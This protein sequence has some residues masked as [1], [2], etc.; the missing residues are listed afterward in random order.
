MICLASEYL[1]AEV[2]CIPKLFVC[3]GA[4]CG[5]PVNREAVTGELVVVVDVAA[6]N[7]AW[8]DGNP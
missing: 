7:P 1:H 6:E 4:R 5:R 3:S 2:T 8:F